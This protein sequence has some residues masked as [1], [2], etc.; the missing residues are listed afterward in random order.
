MCGSQTTSCWRGLT[1][2]PSATMHGGAVGHLVLLELAALGV[3][4]GD[5]A[6][7]LEGD[8]LLV[9]FGVLD[10]DG[11]DVAVLDGAAVDRLDV[12]LDQRCRWRRRRCG[13]YAS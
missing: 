4:D 12:V 8:E 2:S 11:V 6:V 13:T 7:A 5:F 3:D 1:F 9:A 10:L